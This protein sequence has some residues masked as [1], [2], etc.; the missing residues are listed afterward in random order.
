MKILV[1]ILGVTLMSS[2]ADTENK[3]VDL[4]SGDE[5]VEQ[6]ESG[7]R[8]SQGDGEIEGKSEGEDESESEGK[9]ALRVPQGEGTGEWTYKVVM[10]SEKNWGYQL[11][12]N[13]KMII[14]QTTIP[15]VQGMAGFDSQEKA[16]RTAKHIISKLEKG[17]FPP[18]VDKK[19]LDSLKVLRD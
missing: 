13:G 1:F 15:S 6:S 14:N 12:Q 18:T 8:V 2:C 17:V 9:S 7:L 19:E 11:F 16:D 5:I 10:N 4:R 3:V